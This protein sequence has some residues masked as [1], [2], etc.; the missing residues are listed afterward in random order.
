MERNLQ[1]SFG[2]GLIPHVD[3]SDPEKNISPKNTRTLAPVP[4]GLALTRWVVEVAAGNGLHR[5]LPTG[6][7]D[8]IRNLYEMGRQSP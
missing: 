4:L 5:P 2:G 1:L 6:E 8:S 7:E 3:P